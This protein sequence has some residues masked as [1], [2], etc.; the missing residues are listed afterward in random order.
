MN[1]ALRFN[2]PLALSFSASCTFARASGASAASWRTSVVYLETA[3]KRDRRFVW[4]VGGWATLTDAG[5]A[6]L[7]RSL[8]YCPTS[9]K[10]AYKS[11]GK[12][13]RKSLRL[14]SVEKTKRSVRK[15]CA[16]M[17]SWL[18]PQLALPSSS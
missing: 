6:R 12:S 4:S 10:E 1:V 2:W 17:L 11:G 13:R 3:N 7:C 18:L 9:M 15:A 16:A 8:S 5:W 14:R